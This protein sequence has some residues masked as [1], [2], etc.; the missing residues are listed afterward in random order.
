M[1]ILKLEKNIQQDINSISLLLLMSIKDE[2]K[3]S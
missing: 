1:K 3:I 2:G